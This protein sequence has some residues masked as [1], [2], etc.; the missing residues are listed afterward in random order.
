MQL[1]L[2]NG[3]SDALALALAEI[4]MVWSLWKTD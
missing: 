1:A 4:Q 3:A 2:D